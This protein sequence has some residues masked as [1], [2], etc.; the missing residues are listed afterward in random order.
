VT[1]RPISGRVI[2]DCR[3]HAEEGR[4]SGLS[5]HSWPAKLRVPELR[6]SENPLQK[7]NGLGLM[8]S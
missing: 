1:S 3:Q 2:F 8:H 6:N 5:S 4:V 7:E